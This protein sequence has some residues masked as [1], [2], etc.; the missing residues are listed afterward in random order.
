MHLLQFKIAI[1]VMG[2]PK[3]LPDDGDHIVNLDDFQ[4][5][6][7][8]GRSRS[9]DGTWFKLIITGIIETSKAV[10]L[11]ITFAVESFMWSASRVLNK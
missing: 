6:Q 11:R 10:T 9:F 5:P 4:P 7:W 3:Y 8:Q 2:R 1:V